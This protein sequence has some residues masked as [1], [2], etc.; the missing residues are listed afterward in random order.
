MLPAFPDPAAQWLTC[1]HEIGHGAPICLL[2]NTGII[3]KDPAPSSR[4]PEDCNVVHP[5]VANHAMKAVQRSA[6]LSAALR[7]SRSWRS[8]RGGR[9]ARVATGNLE[10]LFHA[11]GGLDHGENQ[12]KKVSTGAGAGPYQGQNERLGTPREPAL[13]FHCFS[14]VALTAVLPLLRLAKLS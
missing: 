12:P 5:T 4:A 10:D 6:T 9:G 14:G 7:R 13:C 3:E 11:E 8:L 1:H 2:F